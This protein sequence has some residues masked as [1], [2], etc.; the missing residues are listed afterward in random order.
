MA[1]HL[2]HLT[3]THL[4]LH[5][6]KDTKIQNGLLKI[7][8][9]A[10]VSSHGKN[11]FR[12]QKCRKDHKGFLV[13]SSLRNTFVFARFLEDSFSYSGIDVNIK[14]VPTDQNFEGI[15]LSIETE[16]KTDL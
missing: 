15:V 7:Y 5:F 9:K 8:R 14:Y 6:G 10:K 3:I 1:L 12:N 13:W 16:R 11:V 2:L 4:H